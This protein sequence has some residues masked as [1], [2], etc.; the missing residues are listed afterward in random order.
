MLIR[1]NGDNRTFFLSPLNGK[2]EQNNEINKVDNEGT[3]SVERGI[4]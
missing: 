3:F 1:S 2:K 4:V